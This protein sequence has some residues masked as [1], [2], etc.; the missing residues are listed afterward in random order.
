MLIDCTED[1][2]GAKGMTIAEAAAH[3]VTH[4]T[5]TNKKKIVDDP[6]ASSKQG[7]KPRK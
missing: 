3:A 4:G 1:N 6:N 2:C 5:A 7:R